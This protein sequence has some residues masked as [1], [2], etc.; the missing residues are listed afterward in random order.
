MD[1]FRPLSFSLIVALLALAA[2]PSQVRA[3][4]QSG[5]T[6][7][8]TA[9][10][11]QYTTGIEPD[12]QHGA[13]VTWKGGANFDVCL[14][15]VTVTGR[16]SPGWPAAGVVVKAGTGV[17]HNEK[18][19]APDGTGGIIVVWE[20]VGGVFAKRILGSGATA[21]GWPEGGTLVTAT[22]GY[23]SDVTS[24]GYGGALVTA[25]ASE[26]TLY[27]QRVLASG[28]I[29]P[30]WPATGALL[31]AR[32]KNYAQP[33]YPKVAPDGAGGAIVTWSVSPDYNSYKLNVYAQHVT[34]M[35]VVDPGWPTGGLA[36]CSADGQQSGPSIAQDRAG[37]AI[38]A[39]DDYRNGV[40][41]TYA[42]HVTSSG[43]ISFSWPVNGARIST[44]SSS[45]VMAAPDGTGG[46][47][48]VWEEEASGSTRVLRITGSGAV[49]PGWPSA[50]VEVVP[51]AGLPYE[52]VP[53]SSGGVF[54]S[55]NI[56]SQLIVVQHITGTG[57]TADGWPADGVWLS[58]NGGGASLAPE[59]SAGVIV[60][61]E[62]YRSTDIKAYALRISATG[63]T[64]D[65]PEATG[66]RFRLLSVGPNPL[67]DRM[68]VTFS[69]PASCTVRA[70]IF[71][72]SGRFVRKLGD[73]RVWEPGTHSMSWDGRDERGDRVRSGVYFVNLQAGADAA[74]RKVIVLH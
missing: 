19:N 51:G 63:G 42:Q 18:Y 68:G 20:E 3:Q 21:P 60:A 72:A 64:V 61:W 66:H 28:S 56:Q 69:L 57:A 6:P 11:D 39:W 53:D 13:F 7:L 71:D 41:N 35:G 65:V 23:L 2:A 34:S 52:A 33:I 17:D 1:L 43:G 44:V 45:T 32:G 26:S 14:Q 49:V 25:S 74:V 16:I 30:G 54:V 10:G 47:T 4:W 40:C 46:A 70:R 59:G 37:G 15:H 5:G 67:H 48:L 24:D 58:V 55:W 31:P 36:V 27:V 62:D 9:T 22:S 29:A 12:G 38:I 8:S 73:D 50:G